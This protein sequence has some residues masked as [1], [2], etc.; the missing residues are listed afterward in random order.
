MAR[1]VH[2]AFGGLDGARKIIG[3]IGSGKARPSGI[4]YIFDIL[5]SDGLARKACLSVVEADKGLK[6]LLR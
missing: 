3:C 5:D 6:R 4:F 2:V 1:L